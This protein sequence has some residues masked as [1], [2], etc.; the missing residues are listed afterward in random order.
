MAEARQR[1]DDQIADLAGVVQRDDIDVNTYFVEGSPR[2]P[3]AS[4]AA[5]A[6]LLVVG[7]RGR[8]AIGSALLGSVSTWLLHHVTRPIAVVP[9]RTPESQPAG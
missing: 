4:H 6:D 5:D 3:I 9:H 7:A 2:E 1:F 8:G